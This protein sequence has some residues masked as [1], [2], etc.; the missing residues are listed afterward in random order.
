MALGVVG[1]HPHVLHQAGHR[2]EH[3]VL[4]KKAGAGTLCRALLQVS[5]FNFVRSTRVNVSR[6]CTDDTEVHS[7]ATPS[8]LCVYSKQSPYQAQ[9]WAAAVSAPL[10]QSSVPRALA[11][12]LTDVGRV[13][14]TSSDQG[15]AGRGHP[16]QPSAYLL[17]SKPAVGPG[18]PLPLEGRAVGRKGAS[19]VPLPLHGRAR[20]FAA[21]DSNC[22]PGSCMCSGTG[23]RARTSGFPARKQQ[24]P[25]SL[26]QDHSRCASRRSSV[27]AL[28]IGPYQTLL[29]PEIEWTA[30][31]VLSIFYVPNTA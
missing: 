10:L 25:D 5:T 3:S 19:R 2:P 17:I 7:E 13:V 31:K 4:S 6:P 8:R 16:R 20:A 24:P 11:K 23:R 18:L 29:V 15:L 21:P 9:I 30:T 28:G 1:C 27:S 14:R 26:W 12:R 22:R